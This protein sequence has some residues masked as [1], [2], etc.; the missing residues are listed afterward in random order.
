MRLDWMDKANCYGADPDWFHPPEEHPQLAE[1]GLALC[2]PCPVKEDCFLY[3]MSFP[4]IEDLY[5]VY[6]ATTAKQRSKIRKLTGADHHMTYWMK[7]REE[8]EN[9]KGL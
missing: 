9:N 2:E 3:A 1:F 6:G 4:Q 7:L 5:G 8:R